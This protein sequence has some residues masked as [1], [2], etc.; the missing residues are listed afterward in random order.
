MTTSAMP[1]KPAKPLSLWSNFFLFNWLYTW[2]V[3]IAIAALDKTKAITFRLRTFESARF[4]G[5]RLQTA[6]TDEKNKNKK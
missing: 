2:C 1:K 3:P 5:D 6:W 4:N